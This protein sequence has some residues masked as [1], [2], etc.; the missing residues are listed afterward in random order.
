MKILYFSYLLQEQQQY[1]YQ[2]HLLTL[3]QRAKA[4][5]LGQQQPPV[6]NDAPEQ[7]KEVREILVSSGL[8]EPSLNYE[9]MLPHPTDGEPPV[10]SVEHKVCYSK[11][12]YYI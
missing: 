2:Q 5:A 6:V 9:P 8:S 7:R 3:Q 1:W 11:K 4:H 12:C 10:S